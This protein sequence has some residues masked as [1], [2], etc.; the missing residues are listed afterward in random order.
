MKDRE[1]AFQNSIKS[2]AYNKSLYDKNRK[3]YIFNVGDMVYVEN[4]NKL[5]RKKLDEIRIGPYE[6]VEKISNS[7]YKVNLGHK[8]EESNFFHISKLIPDKSQEN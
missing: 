7:I 1:I 2:H 8:K 6:I 5:N 4:G 3:D